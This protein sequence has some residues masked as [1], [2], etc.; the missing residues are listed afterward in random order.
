MSDIV[1][2]LKLLGDPTRLRILALL[3]R[4]ELSVAEL[5]DILDM[6]Q[7]RI[8]SHLALLRNAAVVED[9]REGKRSFYTHIPLPNAAAQQLLE[10]SLRAADADP[11]I[12]RDAITMDR[13][14][15]R[16]R[17]EAEAFFNTIAGRLDKVGCPGRS[18]KA[19]GHF[20]LQLVPHI[21]IADLGAGEGHLSQLLAQRAKSVTC[22][23]NSKE[24]VKIG[25][26]NARDAALTNLHFLHGDIEAVPLPDQSVDLALLSQA[27]HHARRPTLALSEAFRILRPGGLIIVIDLNA[28]TFEQ[29]RDLYADQWLGFPANDL[30]HWLRSVGFAHISVDCV[31]RTDQPPHFETLLAV[32]KRPL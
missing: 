27:L 22:I 16:R 23:D 6:G 20:L 5:Q 26:Q 28:H 21:D 31:D 12:Q 2:L 18:W 3:N 29:A 4:A 10:A 30:Y 25:A 8:S 17:D 1:D 13:I 15:Q 24:M 19:I 9:R 7:S 11:A 14:L 32:A